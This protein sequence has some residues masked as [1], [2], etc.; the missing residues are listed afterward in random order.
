MKKI[1]VIFITL[2]VIAGTISIFFLTKEEKTFFYCMVKTHHIYSYD[3]INKTKFNF[4]VNDLEHPIVDID[5]YSKIEVFNDK[6]MIDLSP[7]EVTFSH[8]ESLNKEIY[9]SFVL[10]TIIPNMNQ[11]FIIEEAFISITLKNNFKVTCEIGVFEYINTPLSQDTIF[12]SKIS[13][14][15]GINY[16]NSRLKTITIETDS[17]GK[18]LK[19]VVV[20]KLFVSLFEISDNN[21]IIITIPQENYVLLS[22]PLILV[23]DDS[24][25]IIN[26]MVF[27]REYSLLE[28]NIRLVEY[29]YFN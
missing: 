21:T 25:Q 23:F 9:H 18:T 5:M 14:L 12:I 27:F 16:S 22:T 19:E 13:G 2:V 20:S 17:I 29:G 26:Y 24:E 15:K 10:E 7:Y 6:Q 8:S 3:G 28:T 11:D 1:I 4:F